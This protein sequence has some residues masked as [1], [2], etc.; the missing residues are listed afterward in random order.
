[1][2]SEIL[3]CLSIQEKILF[4]NVYITGEIDGWNLDTYFVPLYA[5]Q[6]VCTQRCF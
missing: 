3:V 1:M 4:K 5:A 6:L 2:I